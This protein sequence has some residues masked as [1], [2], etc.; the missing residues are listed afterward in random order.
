MSFVIG[1]IPTL[2]L[3]GILAAYWGEPLVFVI[4]AP[5]AY[6]FSWL[7]WAVGMYFAGTESMYYANVFGRWLVR[8]TVE[9]LM[10]RRSKDEDEPGQPS[11][12]PA[13]STSTNSSTSE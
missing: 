1:G 13:D 9:R 6:G 7:V 8:V 2:A 12:P 10:G 4:G 5:A 3:I 11:E